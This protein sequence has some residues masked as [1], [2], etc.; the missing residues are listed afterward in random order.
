ME[1]GEEE[2]VKRRIYLTLERGRDI[3]LRNLFR[4]LFIAG[5]FEAPKD[6]VATNNDTTSGTGTPSATGGG[7]GTAAA[8]SSAPVRRTRVPVQEF[9]AALQLAGFEVGD[10]EGGVDPAEVEC[11]TANAIYKVSAFTSNI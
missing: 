7:S 9:A 1:A 6:A 3:L 5:G 10:G 4:K 2:F 8:G 11:L